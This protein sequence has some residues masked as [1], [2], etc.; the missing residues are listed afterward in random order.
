MKSSRPNLF[1][2]A[3][4]ATTLLLRCAT[5]PGT[6]TPVSGGSITFRYATGDL[7]VITNVQG[8][9]LIAAAVLF[10]RDS[11]GTLVQATEIEDGVSVTWPDAVSFELPDCSARPNLVSFEIHATSKIFNYTYPESCVPAPNEDVSG[12]ATLVITNAAGN[13]RTINDSTSAVTEQT[14]TSS[15]TWT[16]PSGV[17]SVTVECWGGGGGGGGG[18]SD[19]LDRVG[20]GGGAGGAY[21]KKLSLSVSPGTTYTVTVGAGGAGGLGGN[22]TSTDGASGGDTWFQSTGTVFAQGGS[23]GDS[24]VQGGNGGTGGNISAGVGDILYGGGHGRDGGTGALQYGGGGGSSAGTQANG[25]TG[26]GSAAGTAPSGGGSGGNG[27]FAS[28]PYT[29]FAGSSPGG[30]GGGGKSG[31]DGGVGANGKVIID[32]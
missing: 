28:S 14:Y 18:D 21:T 5:D 22:Q 10:D 16:A 26:S 20:G 7:R 9:E 27:G 15:G 25:N 11:S 30:G 19:P 2:V 17:T 4:I 32:W 23:E 3:L 1:C 13:T 24:G 12:Q 8:R 6:N 29:G 31:Y